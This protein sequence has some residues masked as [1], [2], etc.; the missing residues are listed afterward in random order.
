MNIYDLYK[1]AQLAAKQMNLSEEEFAE[2]LKNKLL[3]DHT[4]PQEIKAELLKYK[5]TSK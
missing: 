5:N 1:G 4:V 3:D 2:K